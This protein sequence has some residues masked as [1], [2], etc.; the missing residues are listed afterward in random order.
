MRNESEKRPANA[1][2]DAEA[3]RLS[4]IYE[5]MRDRL[6]DMRLSNP[7][8]NY[9]HR[10][11]SKSQLQIVDE[12]PEEIHR[13]LAGGG[14]VDMAPLPEPEGMPADEDTEEFRSEFD[15][16]RVADVDYLTEIEA[17]EATGRADEYAL[18]EAENRLRA[19]LRERLGM[20]PRPSRRTVNPVEHARSLGIDPS[21]E[22]PAARQKEGHADRALQTLKW[23]DTLEAVLDRIAD[24]A[25]L[26]EQE[27]GLSTL[28]LVFGFLEWAE[29]GDVQK[30]MHAPL[31]LLPV[32]LE[33]RKVRGRIVHALSA[34]G[35]AETN[36]SLEKKLLTD[37][38]IVLPA[39]AAD[40]DGPGSV[41]AYFEAVREAV[42][43]ESGDWRVRRFVT[44]GHFAFG[45]L[46]MYADL[47][48]A[49]WAGHP[50]L[51]P[52]IG[53]ILRGTEIA[54]DG[55]AG[56]A[57]APDDHDIDDP[58]VEAVAPYLVLDADASQHSAVVD[59]MAGN[60]LVIQGP[61]GTGKSQTIANIVANALAKGKTVLF[62][63]EKMAALEV[64]KRRLDEVGL[65]DFCL[66]VHSDKAVPK[67][68]IDSLKQRHE[69]GYS[70]KR[71]AMAT[72]IGWEE[73]RR[74]IRAYL[75]ALHRETEVG[76]PFD[77]FWRAVRARGDLGERLALFRRTD[78]AGE[79][80]VGEAAFQ[81]ALG[82][83]DR[84]CSEVADFEKA[85]GPIT[86][87]SWSR[88]HFP[89]D[90][91]PG[92]THGL[93]DAFERLRDA[94]SA[95]AAKASAP[96]FDATSASALDAAAALHDALPRKAPSDAWLAALAPF[97][98]AAALRFSAKI[99]E[100]DT[101][102]AALDLPAGLDASD[103]ELRRLAAVSLPLVATEQRE[104][105]PAET[106]QMVEEA[107]REAEHAIAAA[108]TAVEAARRLGLPETLPAAALPCLY[109]LGH[110]LGPIDADIR[111]WLGEVRVD[112]P[113]LADVAA[114]AADL[115]ADEAS[116]RG[117]FPGV[118]GDWPAPDA[119][120][121]AAA[122]AGRSGL[123]RLFA[124]TRLVDAV[125]AQLGLPPRMRLPAEDYETL[126]DH[127]RELGAFLADRTLPALFGRLWRGLDTPF[128]AAAAARKSLDD[129]IALILP[130]AGGQLIAERLAEGGAATIEGLVR[131]VPSVAPYV[132]LSREQ[133]QRFGTTPIAELGDAILAARDADTALL[134]G[135]DE[136]RLAAV[137]ASW[138]DIETSLGDLSALEAAELALA[139]DPHASLTAM[140]R[141]DRTGFDEAADWLDRLAATDRSS[142]AAALARPGGGAVRDALAE[143]VAA[144][145]PLLAA[146]RAE[147]AGIARE[148]GV[149]GFDGED[150]K[151]LGESVAALA[152]RRDE[153][154]QWL[155]VRSAR[156]DAEQAGLGPFLAEAEARGVQ[157]AELP[158]LFT[159]LVAEQR[160][161]QLRRTDRILSRTGGAKLAA[162]RSEFRKRDRQRRDRDRLAVRAAVIGRQ[163]LPGS[164]YG[165]RRT[166]TESPFLNNEFGKVKAFRPV[167]ELMRQAGRSVQALKPCFMMS[168]LSLAKF[169]PARALTFDLLVIDEASQMRPEDALGG[170]LRARQIVVVGDPK[171]L[172]PTD[173]FQ[174][175]AADADGLD[176]DDD[177]D[178]ESILEAC[179]KTFRQLRQLKWHYRSR[180]ESLIA[181]SNREIYEPE[182]RRLITFPAASP[183]SFSI[184]R[185]RVRGVFEQR[186]NAPEAQ[187]IADEALRFMHRHAGDEEPP[188][189]GLV[190]M[191]GEQAELIQEEMRLR[192][193]G[194][195]AAET[196]RKKVAE[197][198]EPVFI[199]NLE[200]VQGD[201]RD[202]ILISLT[203]GPRESDG[204]VMQR[205]GPV[206]KKQGDRRL[207]VLFTRARRRIG[208]VTSMDSGDV[209]PSETSSRGVHLLKRYLAYVETGGRAEGVATEREPDSDF[210]I[211][212]ADRLE[213]LGF[214]VRHQVGVSG[215]RIDLA[216][217][218]PAR[219]EH[220]LAGIECDGAQ[221][222]SGRSARD[223]DRLR[224][225]VL[226]GLGW[227]I[228]RVWSTDWFDNPDRQAEL[229][230]AE[231]RRL[232]AEPRLAESFHAFDTGDATMPEPEAREPETPGPA[233][234]DALAAETFDD[235]SSRPALV[236]EDGPSPQAVPAEPAADGD[237]GPLPEPWTAPR[238]SP[239]EARMALAAFRDRV[240]APSIEGWEPERSLLRAGLIETFVEQR[241]LEDGDWYSRVPQYLRRNTNGAER[242]R[243]FEEVCEI[244]GRIAG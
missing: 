22:L 19:R 203:Y 83:L 228:L 140:I 188:T 7:M 206:A 9:R 186:R 102:A 171:Q 135:D 85:F 222:H 235:A 187:R 231:L 41:E 88:L 126:A 156:Q 20:P 184:D 210:E 145:R 10:P 99:A 32:R 94:L 25:R 178:D 13:H 144:T 39:F 130:V 189:L 49:Q 4:R 35:L 63:A 15:H 73:A 8:L 118:K 173:F 143:H 121:A 208:L 24:T 51:S 132:R 129:T 36:L 225:D 3:A 234:A 110:A 47:E 204:P 74:D 76:R 119:L 109:L 57:S 104:A 139:H 84:Y 190:A 214:S 122:E 244:V 201:E 155:G 6:L 107:A 193:T 89:A 181:F 82:R 138:S 148:F 217:I 223:R 133:R 174:R 95:L 52:L 152:G 103:M 59:V 67:R 93:G 198:G 16:A 113:R 213:R 117:R 163:A 209:R 18:A 226:E 168:P 23:P 112:R 191:N 221:Y 194:D 185:I 14:S 233:P 136:R 50:A 96:P 202:Y 175:T 31:L 111:A 45:R 220:Y 44:L 124:G 125:N 160:G 177:S 61:P 195:E 98:P 237:A 183:G 169:V 141:S 137:E 192:W 78:I 62:L 127:A 157:T 34:A 64:V 212:V 229:L 150:L 131:A 170:M 77:Q 72:D 38:G 149:E 56:L 27:M 158:L 105:W 172:P 147:I 236:A 154:S 86:T 200:N 232:A 106:Y 115:L 91:N 100:A 11:S 53:A 101:L 37:F 239:A 116:W 21:I 165:P 28:F 240:I 2:D 68:V 238:L 182:G 48:P 167:R 207:N 161:Q 120:D 162:H 60:N 151:A 55:G 92:L 134:A 1:I 42:A 218:D 66:E 197:R 43:A 69:R 205:F 211:H 65:G 159:G 153:L 75:E 128:G 12:V 179:H 29:R 164:D 70:E 33:A 166:W 219:P 81:K 26:A 97:E 71:A 30:R 230:A 243:Y 180:C 216:V 17:L 87:S 108:A 80:L 40:E 176:G 5:Q 123:S 146:I 142:L 242:K 58:A 79:V 241:I 114:A 196:Y 54:G 90:A 199:K 46:A 215:Y 227:T 224:Q